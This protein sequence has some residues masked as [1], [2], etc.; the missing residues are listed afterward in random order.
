MT[1][2]T[3]EDAQ[4]QL[5][6]LV[7]NLQ[8]GDEILITQE[9]QLVARLVRERPQG[10]ERRRLGTAIGQ[11]EIVAEDDEHLRAFKEYMP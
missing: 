9:N 3:L 2:I 7:A 6:S 10:Q 4:A 8:P 1:T 5:A 11:I